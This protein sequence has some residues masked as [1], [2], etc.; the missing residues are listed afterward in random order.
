MMIFYK[1]DENHFRI[2]NKGVINVFYLKQV[3]KLRLE[4][5]RDL[6]LNIVLMC[7][8]FVCLSVAT[9]IIDLYAPVVVVSYLCSVLFF[10]L[11]LKYQAYSYKIMIVNNELLTIEYTANILEI[12]NIEHI[13]S[14]INKVL[15]KE[16]DNYTFTGKDARNSCI[17]TKYL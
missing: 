14:K 3:N 13:V 16:L 6:K 15:T 4:K 11:S 7:S 5:Q 9:Y 17:E 2:K 8:A 1:S 10:M 12:E